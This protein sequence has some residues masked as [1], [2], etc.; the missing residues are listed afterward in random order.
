MSKESELTDK[1]K[2][3]ELP[4]GWYWVDYYSVDGA[5]MLE[6]I[7]QHNGFGY[8]EK[9]LVQAV[10]AEVPDYVEWQALNGN[11]DSVMQTNQALCKKLAELKELLKDARNV[12]KMVDTYYG[13]Y[14]S[15]KGF[16]IVER[17]DEVLK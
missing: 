16:L 13:D 11:M 5:V 9:E 8:E 15:T 3:G 6:Y 4:S 12:L 17:I 14:D 2:K 10:L 7:P 1:W